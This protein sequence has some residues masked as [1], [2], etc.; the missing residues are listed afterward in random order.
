MT[1]KQ[2]LEKLES[3]KNIIKE[4]IKDR[5]DNNEDAQ[6]TVIQSITTLMNLAIELSKGGK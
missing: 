5:Y 2:K 1:N 3:K 4:L 6:N